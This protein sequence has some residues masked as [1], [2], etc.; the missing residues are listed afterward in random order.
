M[1]KIFLLREDFD[2]ASTHF[3]MALNVDPDFIAP[4]FELM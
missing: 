2:E 4:R 3:E 1:G